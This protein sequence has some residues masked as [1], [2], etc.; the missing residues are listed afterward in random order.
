MT[1]QILKH[2]HLPTTPL[3]IT[4]GRKVS[5]YAHFDAGA[6]SIRDETGTRFTPRQ[7]LQLFDLPSDYHS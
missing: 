1:R 4:F 2:L 3:E 7:N 6:K 5:N